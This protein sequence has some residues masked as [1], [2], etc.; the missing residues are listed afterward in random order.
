MPSST[1]Q[2]GSPSPVAIYPPA[3]PRRKITNYGWSTNPRAAPYKGGSST[4]LIIPTIRL[5]SSG[6]DATDHAPHRNKA[7]PG[8]A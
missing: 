8:L 1:A 7:D 5:V 6:A 2:T 3:P 4:P